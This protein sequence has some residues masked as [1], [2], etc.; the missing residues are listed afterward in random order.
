MWILKQY[1]DN[2][3]NVICED[4]ELE[5]NE[6]E[7]VVANYER[8]YFPNCTFNFTSPTHQT[9]FTY[10]KVD[11]VNPHTNVINLK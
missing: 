1:L 5:Q 3:S 6:T 2:D 11:N 4:I 7:E 9:G 8:R 10:H